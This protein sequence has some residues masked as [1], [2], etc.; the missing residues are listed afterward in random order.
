MSLIIGK[1]SD[2]C[3]LTDYPVI[4]MD[5]NKHFVKDLDC[6][7][8]NRGSYGRGCELDKVLP[9]LE[10]PTIPRK[11]LTPTVHTTYRPDYGVP[12]PLAPSPSFYGP[13]YGPPSTYPL[14][15]FPTEEPSVSQLPQYIPVRF[16]STL[17]PPINSYPVTPT[18]FDTST[19]PTGT[20]VP[21]LPPTTF[22]HIPEEYT[23]VLV[24]P[25]NRDSV[26]EGLFKDLF[27]PYGL[28]PTTGP[29]LYGTGKKCKKYFIN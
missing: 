3:Y 16:P 19:R 21:S 5:P 10:W 24:K 28:N 13:R 9:S 1:W 25:L 7:I 15:F 26:Q 11:D 18:S 27:D 6:D 2:N 12:P 20:Y 8:Y 4:E 29:S 22:F 17:S 23:P 14:Q